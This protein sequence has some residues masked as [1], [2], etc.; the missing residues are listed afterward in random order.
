MI[1]DFTALKFRVQVRDH[2]KQIGCICFDMTTIMS[3]CRG[4]LFLRHYSTL[5]MPGA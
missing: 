4:I 1:A 2:L 5:S 3:L